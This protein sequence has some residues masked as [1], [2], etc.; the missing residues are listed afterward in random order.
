MFNKKTD[1][2]KRMAVG[3]AIGAAVSSFFHFVFF[4]FLCP[5][6]A[7]VLIE[8]LLY[9]PAKILLLPLIFMFDY[10][11]TF[12]CMTVA[13]ILVW[14][15]TGAVIGARIKKPSSAMTSDG[16]S[17]K[18]KVTVGKVILWLSSITISA[19]IIAGIWIGFVLL[20]FV[21][22]AIGRPALCCLTF[23]SLYIVHETAGIDLPSNAKLLYSSE[24]GWQGRE[25]EA[26]IEINRTDAK[27]LVGNLASS[28]D[29]MD[30][31]NSKD[32]FW[33]DP[34]SCKK[35]EAV[36]YPREKGAV[37]VFVGMDDG[38]RVPVYIEYHD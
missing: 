2:L 15:T 20:Q 10:W 27:K 32:I 26:K 6:P 4:P 29:R 14:A 1:Q 22:L 35:F 37:T 33:W 17:T 25:I 7:F 24:I 36:R 9:T 23:P 11:P 16:A 12:T 34:D 19:L 28:T 13:S 5:Y 3:G 8:H 31:H 21:G 30:F 38:K 18:K